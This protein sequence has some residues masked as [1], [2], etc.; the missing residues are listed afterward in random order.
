MPSKRECETTAKIR[1]IMRVADTFQNE[2]RLIMN[3]RQT[4]G[5]LRVSTT[6]QSLEKFKTDILKFANDRDFGKVDFIQEKVS[7]FRTSWKDR[8][9]FGV[10]NDLGKDDILITPELSR[11][12]RSTLEVLEI[13]KEAKDKSI[14]IYSV[15]EG[16]EL[17]GS[18]QS[19]VMSTMLALFAE[20]EHDFISMR[21]REG[22]AAAKAKGT[23]L[24]RPKGPGKSKLDQHRPEIEA[25]L[26][27]GSTKR[28]IAERYKTSGPNLWNWM[29]KNKIN[30][31]PDIDFA[32]EKAA[33]KDRISKL[34]RRPLSAK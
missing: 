6:D 5:Y 2:R 14:N 26:K 15:K 31:K 23:I 3:K 34:N 13:I 33:L 32:L 1:T 7:G 12:G 24:G 21:T 25:L 22:L 30:I 28:Y 29:R 18:M 10:I 19:K 16:L 11:L 8:K 4:I 9:L 27:T 17:N 20:L